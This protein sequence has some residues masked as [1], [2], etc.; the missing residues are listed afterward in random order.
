[1]E[2]RSTSRLAAP[3]AAGI[4]QIEVNS[5]IGLT[6][7][8]ALRSILRQ[9]P[10]VILVGEIRD[11]ETAEIAIQASLTGHLVLST[12]HTNDAASS[13]TRLVDMGVEPFLVG[14]SL[15][16]AVAQRLVRVLCTECRE[17]YEASEDELKEIGVRPPGRPVR[18]Y[19]ATSCP[20]C[21]NTG[22]AGQMGIF[23]LMMVDDDVRGLIAK[24]IDSKTIKGKAVS[25]G[26]GTLRADGA[27][28][29]LRGLTSVAEVLRATEEEG[30]V[31]QI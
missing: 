18:L 20:A 16:A 25:K 5:K 22:Y 1:M 6:F 17:P 8:A 4:S 9:N 21:H 7:A 3:P 29:V 14:S 28:K 10:D 31:A 2:P 12:I 27:R 15:V 13:I 30:A 24:G 26:M 19:R 11:V 23:E